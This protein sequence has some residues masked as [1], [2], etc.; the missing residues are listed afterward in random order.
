MNE[1]VNELFSAGDK[2]MPKMHLRQPEFTYNA[3]EPYTKYKE[4]IQELQ[5]SGDS[6]YVYQN[7]LYKLCFEHNIAY[8]EFNF[9]PRRLVSNKVLCD[10]ALHM[11]KNP[12][13][14]AYQCRLASIV[15]K[16]S[17]KSRLVLL[18]TQGQELIFRP[19]MSRK[20]YVKHLLEN[21]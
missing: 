3:C 5:K 12:K 13:Y 2:F 17:N 11:I 8:G 14:D 21:F 18:L 1:I 10:K 9:L 7:E 16:F 20:N 15:Y 4:S 19:T 6:R